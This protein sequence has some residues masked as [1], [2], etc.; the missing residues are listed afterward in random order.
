MNERTLRFER[1]EA[2]SKGV[3]TLPKC[4]HSSIRPS[5]CPSSPV[6]VDRRGSYEVDSDC[7]RMENMWIPR[8]RNGRA[9]DDQ[10]TV[11]VQEKS[12]Y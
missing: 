9:P 12:Q 10:G 5:L 2:S 3:I 4:I 1:E 6:A 7:S 8:R 11:T